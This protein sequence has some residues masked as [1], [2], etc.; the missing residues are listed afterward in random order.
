MTL[1][2]ISTIYS[3]QNPKKNKAHTIWVH[4]LHTRYTCIKTK[5]IHWLSHQLKSVHFLLLSI[6]V[7]LLSPFLFCSRSLRESFIGVH[8]VSVRFVC[9]LWLFICLIHS[10]IC[11]L[12][13]SCPLAHTLHIYVYVCNKCTQR[14]LWHL[15]D[16]LSF[17]SLF[18]FRTLNK[19]Y[20]ICWRIVYDTIQATPFLRKK[21]WFFS[22]SVW[23]NRIKP[24]RQQTNRNIIV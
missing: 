1:C 9:W 23:L 5:Q 14:S 2:I 15:K 8:W 20:K 19:K 12:Y 3:Q 4:R 13:R 22:I 7:S 18:L 17:A 6:V 24:Y 21:L 10:L 11:S 16:F